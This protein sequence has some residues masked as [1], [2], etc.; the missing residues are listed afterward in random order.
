MELDLFKP[1]FILYAQSFSL[2]TLDYQTSTSH[3]IAGSASEPGYR[4]G[5]GPAARFNST[6]R[7]AFHQ[8]NATH[9]ILLD[10]SN[11]CVRV[12]SRLSNA[13]STLAGQCQNKGYIDGAASEARFGRLGGG[14]AQRP[15]TNELLISDMQND[16]IRKIDMDTLYVST[17]IEANSP[18]AIAFDPTGI[19]LYYTLSQHIMWINLDTREQVFLNRDASKQHYD[20]PVNSSRFS[21][22]VPDI[23]FLTDK[24]LVVADQFHDSLRLVDLHSGSVSSICKQNKTNWYDQ[25]TGDISQCELTDPNAILPLPAEEKIL[26][27]GQ[28]SIGVLHTRGA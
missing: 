23:H 19:F 24:L 16:C 20:G 12:V 25:T 14:I 13:T 26:I 5:V 1:G 27:G 28:L 11:G 3:L 10:N 15:G 4:E 9:V 2:S 17:L 18:R 22:I 21:N 8:P 6:Y 7:T